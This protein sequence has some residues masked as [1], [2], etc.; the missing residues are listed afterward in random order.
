MIRFG[1]LPWFDHAGGWPEG[2]TKHKPLLSCIHSPD[3]QKR[4]QVRN[5]TMTGKHQFECILHCTVFVYFEELKDYPV[6][7]EG[8]CLDG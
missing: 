6:W 1:P 5:T 2:S 7:W 8:A 4:E 3:I